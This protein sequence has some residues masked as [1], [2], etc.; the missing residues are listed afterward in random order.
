MP[1]LD[2]PNIPLN[3]TDSNSEHS[4][5]PSES[6]TSN[7]APIDI[8]FKCRGI[9]FCNLNIRH[10]KPKIDDLRIILSPEKTINVFGICETFLTPAIDN[11]SINIQGYKIERKNRY[12]SVK[13]QVKTEGFLIYVADHIEY[14]RRLDLEPSEVESIWIEIKIKNSKPFLVC[15]VYRPPSANAE[16]CE[17]FAE[18]IEKSLSITDEIYI[19][20]DINYY[21]KNGGPPSSRWKHIVEVNDL[22][23]II[24]QPTRVTAHSS[25][26]ID[27]LYAP[28]TDRLSEVI[29]PCMA[30]SDHYPICFTRSTAKRTIKRQ[31]H[32]SIQ[33]RCFKKFSDEAFLCELSDTL[34]HFRVSQIDCNQNVDRWTQ[35]LMFFCKHAPVKTKRVKRSSQPGWIS[36]DIKTAINKHD[37]FHNA[38]SWKEY[39]YWRNQTT[40]LIRSAKKGFFTKSISENKNNSF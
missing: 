35:I 37:T 14:E 25:T 10:L 40:S 3:S 31:S 6:V 2:E 12:E 24:D 38:K 28:N 9:Q 8:N 7:R 27:P 20:G 36:D 4:A 15:S 13:F 22:Q 26:T 32:Q 11:I 30:I 17:K 33:Y 5:A 16:W 29:V 18:Q 19:M 1:G 34:H 21:W 39:K 23:Q